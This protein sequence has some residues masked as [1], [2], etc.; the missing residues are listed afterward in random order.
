MKLINKFLLIFILI[1][2]VVL[3]I[4]GVWTYFSFTKVN[5]KE[6]DNEIAG[7]L[8]QIYWLIE[9]GT[10][11]DLLNRDRETNITKLTD[12]L[13]LKEAK[14]FYD[15]TG[16][17]R[18]SQGIIPF[19][20]VRSFKKIGN[21]WYKIEMHNSLLEPDDTLYGTIVSITAISVFL[22]VVSL[23]VGFYVSKKLLR[24][25]HY[26][27]GEIQKFSIQK[28]RKINLPRTSTFEFN[29][30][31]KFVNEMSCKAVDDY[32]NLKEFTENIAHEIRTPLAVAS[33][34]LDL[35]IQKNDLNEGELSLIMDAQQSLKK[36]S[37]IQYALGILSRIQNEEYSTREVV[38]LSQLL[39]K[40]LEQHHDI[41]NL[42]SIELK[43]R[44]QE[45][46]VVENDPVLM[47]ILMT[48]LIQ[49]AIKHNV[50]SD[51][52]VEIELDHT[53]FKISNPGSAIELP[54]DKLL[55]RFRRNGNG[56]DSL[57]LGLAIVKSISDQS[58]YQLSYHFD[59]KTNWHQL[60][61]MFS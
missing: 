3:A 18:G 24:P 20:K 43:C 26:S 6:T 11:L 57:G 13:N 41:F 14:S 7:Q 1:S 50:E 8:Y 58:N 56:S 17:H 46:V 21:D 32:N 48:N 31:N 22:I 38:N 23:I 53:A 27:L 28:G 33:G 34:K 37:K 44:A 35:L 4:G 36:V 30:L 54:A 5:D 40:L 61:V 25:F 16:Y 49:N 52:I 10:S 2:L 19:R 55:E 12:T 15:T 59:A 29:L 9:Q 47:E 51:G 39:D 42:R 45:K 60:S